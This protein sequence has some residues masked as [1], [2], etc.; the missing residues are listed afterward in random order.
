[1]DEKHQIRLMA[2]GMLSEHS[3]RA[4]AVF[5]ACYEAKN[6]RDV[7]AVN[8]AAWWHTIAAEIYRLSRV[9]SAPTYLCAD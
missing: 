2:L 4:G 8:T 1:M 3:T 5:S 7:G 9:R 6:A